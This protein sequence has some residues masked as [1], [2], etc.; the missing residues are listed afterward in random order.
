MTKENPARQSLWPSRAYPTGV[1]YGRDVAANRL[2]RAQ[3]VILLCSL[4]L[5]VVAMHHV[6]MATSPPA[7]AV[8]HVVPAA[9]LGM[10]AT[11]TGDS[12]G[13]H[14][15]TPDGAHGMLHLCLAVLSVIVAFLLMLSSLSRA[16][17]P[18][19]TT[20]VSPR[21]SPVP[22]RPPDGGGRRILTSLCILRT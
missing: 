14:P 6:T 9:Q 5:C 16:S 19:F 21:G 10:T 3:Q 11:V 17:P 12:G 8:T 22:E 13:H 4:A 7:S 20:R 18:S 15:G 1:E 2:G